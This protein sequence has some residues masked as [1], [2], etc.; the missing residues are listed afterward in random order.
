MIRLGKKEE[1][2]QI[3]ECIYDARKYLKASGS[4]QWN[5]PLGYPSVNTLLDDINNNICFVCVRDGIICGVAAFAGVEEEYNQKAAKWKTSGDKYT[6]IHRI[7]VIDSYRG[8]GVAKE[9]LL[10]AE[11]YAK[12][13][14]NI[15]IRIDTHPKNE[16]VQGLVTKLGYEYCG[17][18]IYS[19][20]PVEPTRLIYEKILEA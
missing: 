19:R 14:G 15:S 6:T 3:M 1:I 13:I 18:I 12:S 4:T 8:K 10:Y 2:D 7:A 11:E 16:V 20:I 9:L 5:G 17:E